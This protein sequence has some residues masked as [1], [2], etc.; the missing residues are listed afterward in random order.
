[1]E[2]AFLCDVMSRIEENPW[3]SPSLALLRFSF[4][5]LLGLSEKP[6]SLTIDALLWEISYGGD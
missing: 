2:R 1:M 4:Y 6:D 3:G 5:T